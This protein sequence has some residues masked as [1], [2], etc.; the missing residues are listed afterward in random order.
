MALKQIKVAVASNN[1]GCSSECNECSPVRGIVDNDKTASGTGILVGSIV[2]RAS[3]NVSKWLE[4][5]QCYVNFEFDDTQ[6]AAEVIL[7]PCDVCLVCGCVVE[8]IDKVSAGVEGPPGP[9][10]A[11]GPPG[12]PGSGVLAIV[13]NGDG[14]YDITLDG[15]PISGGPIYTNPIP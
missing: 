6:L 10:G 12:P 14:S 8:L 2:P 9:P 15:V 13:N 5:C 7:L 3:D 1:G 11:A 4:G